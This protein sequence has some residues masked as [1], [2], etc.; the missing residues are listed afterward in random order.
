MKPQPRKLAA[1]AGPQNDWMDEPRSGTIREVDALETFSLGEHWHQALRLCCDRICY[2]IRRLTAS[3]TESR[4]K[5][6]RGRKGG[7]EMRSLATLSHH[8]RN[9][10][11][12]Q[13]NNNDS[14]RCRRITGTLLKTDRLQVARGKTVVSPA[15][16]VIGFLSGRL[17]HVEMSMPTQ[18]D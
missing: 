3:N 11:A 7:V 5:R 18:I 1:A 6:Q 17:R 16:A 8:R 14:D 10:H 15:G 12:M 2:V 9:I 13:I 4:R